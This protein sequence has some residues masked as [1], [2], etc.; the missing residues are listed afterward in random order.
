MSFHFG[1]LTPAPFT[2]N[3]LEELRDAIDFAAALADADQCI[4]TA[5][6]RREALRRRADQD[7]ARM[8]ALTRSMTAAADAA[9][10]GESGSA[11]GALAAEL[12]KLIAQRREA[13]EAAAKRKL[14]EDI[15]AIEAETLAARADY[16]PMLERYLLARDPPTA[17]QTLRVELVGVKKDERRYTADIV[18]RS[19]LG[20]DWSIEVAVP[21]SEDGAAWTEP[22]RVDDVADGL[23][24]VAPHLAGLIKKEV[25]SKKTKVG[26]HFVTK[27]VDDGAT[28]RI[29]IRDEIGKPDGY[30]VTADLAK[31]VVAVAKAGEEDDLTVGA[32][33]VA[34]EDEEPLLAMAAKLRLMAHALPK[35]RLVA[36]RFDGLPFDGENT[37]AQP[38]LVQLVSRL[39]QRLGPL[40][41]EIAVR[42]RSDEELVL[43]RIM[44]DG[45][46]EELFMPKSRLREQLVGLDDAHRDLFAP[47]DSALEA[48]NV[49]EA[50]TIDVDEPAPPSVA[51]SE[52]PAAVVPYARRDSNKQMAAVKP[53]PPPAAK[54]PPP[55]PKSPTP[56]PVLEIEPEEPGP[57]STRT[58]VLVATL[59]EI[60]ALTRD[61]KFDDAFRRYAALVGSPEFKSYRLEDQRQALKL[62]I[63]TKG[64]PQIP[65]EDVRAAH[66]AALPAL[67]A[68]VVQHRDP[69][70]YEMLGMAYVA[71]DEPEKA[72]EIFK[73]ALDIERGRNPGSD[74][75]GDLMR[76]V[77]QL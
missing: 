32:F 20:L 21:V 48:S 53:P 51:R 61:K 4:V 46:R 31:R 13:A 34:A 62:M 76:R 73:K 39:A 47:V 77:S 67:Q 30:D 3:F 71:I 38:K 17:S 14:A 68:L 60:R 52:V 59:K 10:K 35:K 43:R 42:S 75:C 50:Q 57:P 37:D 64:L 22:M 44:E 26:R 70:D 25:K 72:T 74:L 33:P 36:A 41:D 69:A 58:A 18:G 12:T 45:R 56:A 66:R 29:E 24:I 16:F 6:A 1:D 27:I 49:A 40:V 15:R 11:T 65:S 63:F 19:D 5:D 55:P 9:D 7:A 2:T 23:A 8:E 28:L 54:P